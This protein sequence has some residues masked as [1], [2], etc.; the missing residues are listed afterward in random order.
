MAVA[1]HVAADDRAVENVEGGEQGRGAVALVVV[2]HGA[3][4]PLLRGRPGWVRSSAWIW[5]FSSTER[6]TAWAGG[7]T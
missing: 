6:T 1:L 5:F 3:G 2:R 4:A 7:S